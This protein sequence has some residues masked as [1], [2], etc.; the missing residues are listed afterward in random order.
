MELFILMIIIL[1]IFWLICNYILKRFL[2]RYQDLNDYTVSAL[3]YRRT[4][5]FDILALIFIFI[6][7]FKF[8]KWIA[9][10][11]YII[12]AILEGILLI[13][14]FITGIDNDIKNRQ[15]DT[16]LWVLLLSKF[17]NEVSNLIMIFMSFKI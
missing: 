5:M 14:A 1:F 17:L 4:I 7:N 10:A 11:Y 6:F 13:I 2:V 8:I 9:I 16:D 3:K 15:I 12:I